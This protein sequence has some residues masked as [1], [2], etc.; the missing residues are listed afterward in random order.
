MRPSL[1][2]PPSDTKTSATTA[3]EKAPICSCF[4]IGILTRKGMATEAMGFLCVPC[5]RSFASKHIDLICHNLHMCDI[6]A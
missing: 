4:D 3:L 5:C 1:F 6:G 2:F